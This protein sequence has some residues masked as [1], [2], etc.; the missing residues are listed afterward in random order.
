M[1]KHSEVADVT[2]DGG[3]P[4]PTPNATAVET[5]TAAVGRSCAGVAASN[6]EA[7]HTVSR[8]Q[9]IM[10]TPFKQRNKHSRMV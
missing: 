8:N 2:D 6:M 1:Y 3:K 9:H 4:T 10:P 5:P 7:W